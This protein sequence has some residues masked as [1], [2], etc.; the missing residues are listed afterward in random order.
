MVPPNWLKCN[1]GLASASLVGEEG[2][3]I[4]LVVAN[5]L[6]NAAMELI[7]ARLLHQVGDRTGAVAILRRLI[8]RQQLKLCHRV[9]D[10]RVL[11]SAAQSFVG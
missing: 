9:F 6:P 8:Q 2:V 1:G 7:G 10:G 5:K 4:E 3:G 11:R